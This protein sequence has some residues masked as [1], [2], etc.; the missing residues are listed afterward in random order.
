MPYREVLKIWLKTTLVTNVVALLLYERFMAEGNIGKI[1]PSCSLFS[2]C[3]C[4]AWQVESGVQ[5]KCLI[6]SINKFCMCGQV[7]G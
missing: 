6:D 3:I 1:W 4:M 2:V 5:A 7:L